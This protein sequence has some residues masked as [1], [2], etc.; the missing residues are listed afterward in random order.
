VVEHAPHHP[1]V[2]DSIP[3]TYVGTGKDEKAKMLKE[4]IQNVWSVN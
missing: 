4:K 3:A 1:K 2:K